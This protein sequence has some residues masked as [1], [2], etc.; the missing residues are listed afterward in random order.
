MAVQK[1]RVS[2]FSV[3]LAVVG[4]LLLLASVPEFGPAIRAARGDGV[5]G[6]FTARQLQCIQHPGHESCVWTGD[7]A[8][9]DGQ[10]RRQGIEMY[11]SDRGTLTA[12]QIVQAVDTGRETRVYGPDG[13][14]EWVFTGLLALAGLAVL[15]VGV[16][17]IR[18]PRPAAA[19]PP[20]ETP[21]LDEPAPEHT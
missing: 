7:F 2:G 18:K 4:V 10:I 12:G 20:D 13:S 14:D 8:S 15:V 1:R 16:R 9:G 6:A 21:E 5:S 11:G 17:R 19:A 3:V